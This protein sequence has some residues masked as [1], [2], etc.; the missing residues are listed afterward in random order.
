MVLLFY[1]KCIIVYH[2]YGFGLKKKYEYGIIEID[3]YCEVIVDNK[4]DFSYR[5]IKVKNKNIEITP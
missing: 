1:K 5:I 4:S 2:L 3:A